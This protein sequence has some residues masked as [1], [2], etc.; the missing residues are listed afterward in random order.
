MIFL[1]L[2]SCMIGK[3]K[4]MKG[5]NFMKLKLTTK[6]IGGLFCVF[7]FALL[8]GAYGFYAISHITQLNGEAML[9]FAAQAKTVIVT[10]CVIGFIAFTFLNTVVTKSILESIKHI[11]GLV[12]QVANGNIDIKVDVSNVADDEIGSLT[13]DTYKLIGITKSLMNDLANLIHQYTVGG[14]YLFRMD[15]SGYEGAYREL[16]EDI[17]GFVDSFVGDVVKLLE[18]ITEVANGNFE[19]ETELFNGDK[20]IMNDALGAFVGALRGVLTD[21]ANVAQSAAKGKLDTKVDTSKYKG[22]WA[23]LMSDLNELVDAV[24]EPLSGIEYAVTEMAK[25]NFIPMEGEYKGDFEI[26]KNAVNLTVETTLAYIKEITQMLDAI[27][28]GDLTVQSEQEYIGKYA[29]LRYALSTIKRSLSETMGAID[30][31]AEAVLASAGQITQTAVFL[32]DG[33]NKQSGSVQELLVS[34][35]MINEKAK[36]NSDTATDANE[37]SEQSAHYAEDGSEM[38]ERMG[39]SM[40]GINISS[41]NISNII[42]VITEIASQTNLLALNAAIEAARAGDYGK[43]F[44]VVAEEVRN[45]AARSQNSAQETTEMIED[46]GDKIKEGMDVAQRTAESFTTIIEAVHHA[47]ELISQIADISREQVESIGHIH[48][49]VNSISRVVQDNSVISEQ[50]AATSQKLNS[51]AQTL[52]TLVSFFKLRQAA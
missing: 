42:K 19:V 28:K 52:K 40:E 24:S 35:E 16:V 26:V 30:Q 34:I 7:L 39:T 47:S 6:I 33:T 31:A 49:G 45:L 50:C 20:V 36:I 11:A 8:L 15:A 43:G 10:V 3:N 25:G 17:N 37:I 1:L 51:Q 12:S 44:A 14:A 22:D 38:M 23:E 48:D 9:N 5:V 27:S 21:V 13:R 29:P 32:A 4:I 2:S 41:I 18:L 46:T